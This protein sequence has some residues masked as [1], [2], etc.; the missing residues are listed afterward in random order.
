MLAAFPEAL[1]QFLVPATLLTLLFALLIGMATSVLPGIGT[2]LT[3]SLLLGF[4]FSMDPY[5]GIMFLVVLIG[6]GGFSGAITAILINVPGEAQNAASLLDGYPMSR[7]GRAGEAIGAAAVAS[8]LGAA[9]GVFALIAVIPLMRPLILAFGPSELFALTLAGIAMIAVLSRGNAAKGLTAGLI[10]MAI[11]FI[12]TPQAFGGQR[13]TFGIPQ[14][15]EGVP[16]VPLIIGLFAFPEVFKLL[17][18]NRPISRTGSLAPGGLRAGAL[19]AVRNPLTLIRSSL[20]GVGV[21]IVPGVGGAVSPWI[22]YS[23]EKQSSRDPDSFGQGNVL[24]VIAPEASNDSKDGG[25]MMPLLAFGIPGSLAWAIVLSSFSFH[26][27]LPG[28]RLFQNNLDL[29]W[30]MIMALLFANF[31][32]SIVGLLLA[33]L[34]IKVTLI[35]PVVLAPIVLVLAMIGSFASYRAIFA[36]GVTVI[37]GLLAVGMDRAGYPRPPVLIAFVLFPMVERY[38]H[39]SLQVARGSYDFLLNPITFGFLLVMVLV[40][41]SPAVRMLVRRVRSRRATTL[42]PIDTK[43]QGLAVEGPDNN[44]TRP[45]PGWS[46]DDAVNPISGVLVGAVFLVG[47][48]VLY[49]QLPLVREAAARFPRVVL[50]VLIPLLAALVVSDLRSAVVRLGRKHSERVPKEGFSDTWVL[51]W[52]LLLPLMMY[53]FGMVIGAG[54][55]VGLVRIFFEGKGFEVRTLLPALLLAGGTSVF[56]HLVFAQYLNVRLL[57]GV[58]M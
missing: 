18:T 40:S 39:Q 50:L 34:L 15:F 44:E 48:V 38:F 1:S 14:L 11:G 55:Y 42:V 5:V 30:L 13:F 49:L 3:I 45:G 56:V 33:N 7:Q 17:Q 28:Q 41:L 29:V 26:G 6:A 57:T 4:T 21:G 46:S 47:A 8:A 10:G 20:L 22:A 12:G 58:L 24:G 16:L 53:L 9:I 19:A 27:I 25:A 37:V 32:S 43:N 51:G 35:P 36:I 31:G 52:T 23:V 2:V 54:I